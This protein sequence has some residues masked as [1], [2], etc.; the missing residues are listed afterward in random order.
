MSGE[1]TTVELIEDAF[2]EPGPEYGAR[3]AAIRAEACG[4][5]V[6]LVVDL[7]GALVELRFER[8]ALD[9]APGELAGTIRRLAA[10]AGVAA[11]RQGREL[12]GELLP[13]GVDGPRIGARPVEEEGFVA[14][15]V[16]RPR[17]EAEEDFTPVTWA[18][19]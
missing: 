7:H 19:P 4:D 11:L 1:R 5:G 6:A 12:L 3:L 2:A 16:I 13:V 17:P 10:E 8:W 15:P 9:V 18:T 14:G